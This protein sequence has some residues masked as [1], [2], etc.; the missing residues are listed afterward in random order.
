[1]R[2]IVRVE[3]RDREI[4]A[5]GDFNRADDEDVLRAEKLVPTLVPAGDFVKYAMPDEAMENF[6]QRRNRGKRLRA[7][8]ARVD[9]LQAIARFRVFS[10]RG[11]QVGPFNLPGHTEEPF[12]FAA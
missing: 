3:D 5:I 7:V 2:G 8:T 12:A 10:A 6:S 9:D 4:V 11:L 1:M